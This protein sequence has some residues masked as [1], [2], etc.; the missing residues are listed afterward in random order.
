LGC[1]VLLMT[2]QAVWGATE[3]IE[4]NVTSYGETRESAIV[5]AL[6]EAISQIKGINVESKKNLKSRFEEVL[7]ESNSQQARREFVVSTTAG[8]IIGLDAGADETFAAYSEENYTMQIISVGTSSTGIAQGDLV[9]V[10]TGFVLSNSSKTLTIK[11]PNLGTA[12]Q[13]KITITLNRSTES[14]ESFAASSELQQQI[15][16]EAAGYVKSY[17]VISVDKSLDGPGWTAVL[18]V[19]IPIYKASAQANRLRMAVVPFRILSSV[20]EPDFERLFTNSLNSYLTQ[21]RRFAMIDRKYSHEQRKEL[22]LIQGDIFKAE[23][24]A[25]VGNQ[26][27]TDYLILGAVD[28]ANKKTSTIH[29]RTMDKSINRT[30]TQVDLSF[31]ILD[32]ATGQVKYA[33]EYSKSLDGNISL[34]S[35]AKEVADSVGNDIINAIY[36]I[37]VAKIDGNKITLGQ[38]GKTLKIGDKLKLIKYGEK[39]HD[40][41][42]GESL[43]Y[44]EIEIGIV[45]IISVQSKLSTAE[46]IKLTVDDIDHEDRMIVRFIDSAKKNNAKEGIKEEEAK[47]KKKSARHQGG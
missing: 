27:G 10:G 7:V 34:N 2:A 1:L 8:G 24:A 47:L 11:K 20:T 37:L 45:K 14:H 33:N 41:Y 18:F 29:M 6:I 13:V 38:G 42:T 15:L 25:R 19:Q 21:S 16:S 9:P 22:R 36:P 40:Q 39:I 28:S 44:T 30:K 46:I 5:N 4:R 26:L 43:G 31:R 23:E 35:I 32:V 17:E 12:T 3:I